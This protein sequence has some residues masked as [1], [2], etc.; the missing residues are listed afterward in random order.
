MAHDRGRRIRH[1]RH[2]EGR[3][4][5]ARTDPRGVLRGERDRVARALRE[6]ASRGG[7]RQRE[8]SAREARRTVTRE[9]QRER[10]GQGV[11]RGQ[12]QV[13]PET[14]LAVAAQHFGITVDRMFG[15]SVLRGTT[16]A[17]R[18][19]RAAWV[20]Q[21]Q[22]GAPKFEVGWGSN[23]CWG[24]RH[25]V[26]EQQLEDHRIHVRSVGGPGRGLSIRLAGSAIDERTSRSCPS[27]TRAFRSSATAPRIRG[28]TKAR[29]FRPDSSN[30][31]IRSR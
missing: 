10:P 17:L 25:L 30:R 15:D 28:E 16:I 22:V 23:Q 4:Q 31:R 21:Y 29:R 7:W 26:F 6:R 13:F 14:A 20:P 24:A 5:N 27:S 2:R 19:K 12:R 9:R 18:R 3:R 11:G 8:A 1:L